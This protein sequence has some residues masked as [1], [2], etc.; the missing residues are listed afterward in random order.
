MKL[1]RLNTNVKLVYS[2]ILAIGCF[3]L[4]YGVYTSHLSSSFDRPEVRSFV[5]LA[6]G[7]LQARLPDDD[8]MTIVPYAIDGPDTCSFWRLETVLQGC[9]GVG[10]VLLKYQ[11][12]D[13]EQVRAIADQL[14][15]ILAEP[16]NHLDL[17]AP[18]VKRRAAQDLGC[19]GVG[20]RFNL[21]VQAFS[22]TLTPLPEGGG[23]FVHKHIY[24]SKLKGG[25]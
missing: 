11:E 23:Q 2:I 19:G 3:Y 8:T 4:G 12:R 9:R 5:A 20:Q 6:R 22:S 17:L 13:F 14:A 18:N 21:R 1:S 7:A 16:C 25:I 15:K 24:T 10:L